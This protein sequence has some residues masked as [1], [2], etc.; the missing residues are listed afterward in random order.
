MFSAFVIAAAL[1]SMAGAADVPAPPDAQLVLEIRAKAIYPDDKS[2]ASAG[3]S[4]PDSFASYIYIGTTGCELGASNN[5]PTRP[6]SAGWHVTGTV[7]QR[8]G[9]SLLARI[10]WQRLWEQ[11]QRLPGSDKR[12]MDV[13]IHSGDSLPLDEIASVPTGTCKAR[14]ARLEATVSDHLIG[15][16]RAHMSGTVGAGARASGT[17]SG[18]GAGSGSGTSSS[19]SVAFGGATG[20]GG[21]SAGPGFGPGIASTIPMDLDVWL[22]HTR[23]DGAETT[24]HQRVS[25]GQGRFTFR[26]ITIGTAKG[27]ASVQVEGGVQ[28]VVD[29]S[30]ERQ[31]R[32]S[33]QREVTGAASSKGTSLSAYQLPGP[34]DVYAIELPSLRVK[35]E[36]VKADRVSIRVRPAK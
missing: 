23:A 5:E 12:T 35:G 15:P 34:D 10:E 4:G 1:N 16:P 32:V 19:A 29:V 6:L 36:I 20:S 28:A 7:L 24:Q 14:G 13:W 25:G 9:D 8:T 2:F 33:V 27:D 22:V 30:G 3:D 21:A 18:G 31:L 11:S 26:A 17:G